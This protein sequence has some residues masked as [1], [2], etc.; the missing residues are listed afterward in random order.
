MKLDVYEPEP[1]N[2]D[3]YIRTDE[4]ISIVAENYQEQSFFYLFQ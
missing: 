3:D 4:I 2:I 1:Q